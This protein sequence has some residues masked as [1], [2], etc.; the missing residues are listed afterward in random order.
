MDIQLN[1]VHSQSLFFSTRILSSLTLFPI[2]LFTFKNR[3]IRAIKADLPLIPSVFVIMSLF[4]TIVFYQRDKIKS[5][6]FLGFCAVCSVLLSLAASY[7]FL[8]ILGVPLT[9]LTQLLPFVIFGVGLDDAF[10]L[11]GE[12][13]RTCPTKTPEERIQ[14][15]IQHTGLS[16][17]MTSLTSSIAFA[18]GGT[19]SIRAVRWLA[20]YGFLAI[21]IDFL[22]Q[23][24]FF[25]A[26]MVSLI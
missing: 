24:T 4:T 23:I 15:T 3:A 10:I 20:M 8:F 16:I 5:R 26:C 9:S 22:Y 14:D 11:F 21:M 7:G 13:R 6:S 25:V 1:M 12:Y 17:T 2:P 19:S 18:L